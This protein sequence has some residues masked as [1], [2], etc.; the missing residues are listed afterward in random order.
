[1]ARSTLPARNR[2]ELEDIGQS[3][4]ALLQGVWVE[5]VNQALAVPLRE[6]DARQRA[7]AS[8]AETQPGENE[9][10]PGAAD[11]AARPAYHI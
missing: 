11:I 10:L 3:V 8:E 9:H 7:A 6:R 4:R 5:N 2:R 1:M